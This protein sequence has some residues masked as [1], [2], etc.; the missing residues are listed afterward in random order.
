M[1]PR[2]FVRFEEVR[3]SHTKGCILVYN[4]NDLVYYPESEIPPCLLKFFLA[5][6]LELQGYAVAGFS[7]ALGLHPLTSPDANTSSRARSLLPASVPNPHDSE[8]VL[9]ALT[10]VLRRRDQKSA[11]IF[12]YAD[13]LAPAAQ[14]MSAVL[15][16]LHLHAL[17]ILHAWGTD[18]AIRATNN[19]VILISHENQL[20]E[21]LM[22]SGSGYRVVQVNLPTEAEREAFIHFLLALRSRGRTTAFG[23]LGK[24]LTPSEL[25]RITGGL[26]Y[27]DVEELFRLA[28][29]QGAPLTRAM[30]RERKAE[31][32]RQLA[33]NLLEVHEPTHGFEQVAGVRHAVEYFEGLKWRIHAGDP[34]A[35]QAILLAGV[36]GCGKSFLVLALAKEL[37]FPCLVMRNLRERWVGASE[38]NL[39]LVLWVAE[40]LA[41]C[42]IWLDELDQVLGQR[43]TGASADAGTS[44]RLLARIWEFMGSMKHRGR[45]LWVATT[46]RPDLLDA[47]TLDR[48]QVII[49]FLHPT[50][51]EI[52]DLLPLLAKQI[53]RELA[54]DVDAQALGSLPQL[55]E[56]TVRALQEVV[57]MAGT[58]A[59][60]EARQVGSPIRHRHLEEAARDFKPNYNPL[61]HQF[62]AL[63]AIQMTSFQSLLP[64]R[65]GRGRREGYELP[66]CVENLVDAET[67]EIKLPEL[68]EHLSRLQGQLFAERMRQNV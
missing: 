12:D 39:E 63:T 38:R 67:G 34:S 22:R 9:A 41:P 42:L 27:R 56:P 46:N 45:L 32:I 55:Q 31:A 68:Q 25:A 54:E 18:D 23:E 16:P 26:R 37:G 53:G 60:L 36:P 4:T 58:L 40:T 47:A 14:G 3:Q 35:P 2:W 66:A 49:P 65:K 51:S 6:Y 30:V 19:L 5:Q 8:Q 24:D 17:E 7:L 21:L 10:S 20:N 13:H 59:D 62:I 52:A 15:S 1:A 28:A 44:E 64:W 43:G 29:A 50:A 11:I 57:A 61:L 33:Q 48:F